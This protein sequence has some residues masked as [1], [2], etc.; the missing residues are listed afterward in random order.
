WQLNDC[1]PVSSW[2]AIDGD[3]RL[4]P[5]HHELRRVY[6]DR[7]LTLQPSDEGLVLAAVNQAPT[8][9]RTTVTLRRLE[10]DGATVGQGT[11]EVTAAARSVAR[12][13]V[14]AELVPD[15]RSAKEFLVADADGLRATHFPVPDKEFA[16]AQPAFAVE[17]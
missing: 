13:P 16:Y 17:V 10:A 11:Y 15:E 3:G 14:P 2:A 6:A 8:E 9:W 7:L 5:L 12:L 4:K 1:W